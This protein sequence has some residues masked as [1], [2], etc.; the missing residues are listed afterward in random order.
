MTV[1]TQY[2]K[3]MGLQFTPPE[4]A[5]AKEALLNIMKDSKGAVQAANQACDFAQACACKKMK[6][7]LGPRNPQLSKALRRSVKDTAGSV[8]RVFH[9][10]IAQ[11]MLQCIPANPEMPDE[12]P[13]ANKLGLGLIEEELKKAAE[14]L[15]IM[16]HH[17]DAVFQ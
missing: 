9:K 15:R 12:M 11:Y 7:E 16:Y 2:G 8:R 4:L 13:D 6:R 10:R 1:I 3:G 5:D 17:N 14:R